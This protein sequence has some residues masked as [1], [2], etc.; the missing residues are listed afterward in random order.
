MKEGLLPPEGRSPVRRSSAGNLLEDPDA[1]AAATLRPGAAA[2][3]EGLPSGA[4][5]LRVGVG[6]ICCPLIDSRFSWRLF[7]RLFCESH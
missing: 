4:A 2:P 7:W 3:A 1:E 6:G 5:P